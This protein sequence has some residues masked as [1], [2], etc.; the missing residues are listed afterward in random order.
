MVDKELIDT[1]GYCGLICSVCKNTEKGCR[2][3]RS[4][5]GADDCYQRRCCLEKGID[6]CWQC[7]GSPCDMGFF[8]DEVWK[9]LCRGFIRCIKDKGIEEFVSLVQSKLGKVVE[10]GDFRFKKEREIMAMLCDA[11]E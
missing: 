6:G 11:G 8:A 7:D 2:G 1:V 3:C 4:G 10:Y 5:G 9:G